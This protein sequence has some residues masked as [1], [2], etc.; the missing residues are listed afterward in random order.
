MRKKKE[1]DEEVKKQEAEQ[2]EEVERGRL[3]RGVEE[4][5]EEV[6]EEEKGEEW[7]GQWQELWSGFTWT[8]CGC[9]GC[10]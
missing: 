7:E 8:V 9:L 3:F 4:E 10:L 5:E 2:M 1:I 6:M